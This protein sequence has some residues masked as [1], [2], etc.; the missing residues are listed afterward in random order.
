[1][2]LTQ[3]NLSQSILS[4]LAHAGRL[5]IILPL[6]VGNVAQAATAEL[7][8]ARRIHDR[9]TGVPPTNAKLIEMETLIVDGSGSTAS[10]EAAAAIAMENPAFYNVTLKNFAAPWTN[11]DQ[12]VFVRLNDYTATVVGMI[13]DDVDFREVLSGDILYTANGRASPDYSHT[14]NAHYEALEDMGPVAGDL[15]DD[16]ILV[17]T[18]QSSIPGGLPAAATAGIMTTRAAAQSFFSDGTNR[19]MFRFTLMNHLCTDL[20]PLK[21]VSRV[22]DRVRQDVSRSPGGDSRIYMFS[23]VGCHAGMDGLGGAYAKYNFN[24]ETG[25]LDYAKA[26]TPND[27]SL[28]GY[29][30]NGITNKYHNNADNFK[31]GYIATDDSWVNYWRNGQNKLLGWSSVPAAGITIDSRGHAN[32]SG[33]KS[34]GAELANSRAFASCQVKKAFK[35]VCLRDSDDYAADR[36]QVDSITTDFTGNNY[37]MKS[38]FGKVAAYCSQ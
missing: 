22:P 23:C 25:R 30:A 31:S 1:M 15:S 17:K 20:E 4:L 38:V 29:S 32:G 5:S 16:S 11:E 2:P 24:T 34:M 12:S 28:N 27:T 3:Q 14:S 9:L 10:L 21:D 35:A 7:D 36:A 18:E 13:R 33:A 8:Q 6:L 26:E 37:N 19:G